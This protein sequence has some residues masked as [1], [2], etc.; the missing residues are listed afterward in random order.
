MGGVSLHV[1][2]VQI[3]LLYLRNGLSRPCS[4]QG[5]ESEVTKYVLS[6]SHADRVGHLCTSSTLNLNLRILSFRVAKLRH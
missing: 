4:N 5:Y 3:E 6:T 1:L 2:H